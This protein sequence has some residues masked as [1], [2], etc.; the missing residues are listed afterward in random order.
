MH[1][2]TRGLYTS[3][4]ISNNNYGKNLL[5]NHKYK[6]Q[7][8]SYHSNALLLNNAISIMHELTIHIATA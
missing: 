5:L 1:V 3:S 7:M 8:S 4:C 6:Y 2:M